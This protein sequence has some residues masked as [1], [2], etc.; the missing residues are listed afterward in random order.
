M[1]QIN[2]HAMYVK[3]TN[4]RYRRKIYINTNTSMSKMDF[5][6]C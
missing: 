3:T 1:T 6:Y 5:A 2:I 4:K